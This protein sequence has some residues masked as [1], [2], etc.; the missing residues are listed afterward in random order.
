MHVTVIMSIIKGTIITFA[1]CNPLFPRL[2]TRSAIMPENT[3]YGNAKPVTSLTVPS[4][5]ASIAERTMRAL[6]TMTPSTALRALPN[7]AAF[8]ADILSVCRR[9]P[10]NSSTQENENMSTPQK[11][12]TNKDGLQ[13]KNAAIS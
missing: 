3:P 7:I 1:T 8:T 4:M 5:P 12:G 10:T 13:P 6:N 2:S 9:R 11:I